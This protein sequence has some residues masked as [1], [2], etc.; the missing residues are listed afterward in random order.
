MAQAR[1]EKKCDL[2]MK[3]GVT[4]G[5]VYPRAIVELSRQYQFSSIGG[6]SAGAIAAAVAAAAEYAR[7]GGKSDA[8]DELNQLPVWLGGSS[9]D[10]KHSNLFHLFQPMPTMAK[11]YSVA[12]A[13]LGKSTVG[14]ATATLLAALR[15]F[16]IA[17]LLGVLPGVFFAVMTFQTAPESLR[18]LGQ[19]L[20]ALL[21]LVG[22]LIGIL[23]STIG[24]AARMPR[25]GW[26]ICSG[27]TEDSSGKSP[28]LVPW[29]A[30]YLDNL[31][32]KTNG[33][34]LTF[35]DLQD[36]G[37]NLQMITTNLTNGRPYSMPFGEHTHFFFKTEELRRFFPEY[38]VNSMDKHQGTRSSR[39]RDGEVQSTGLS[40]LPDAKD[41]PVILAVRM[42]LSFPFLFCPIP[43]YGVDFGFGPKTAAGS[44]YIPEPC[45]FVDG[46]LTNNFPLNLFDHPIPRWP[47]FGINLRDIDDGRHNQEVFIP[48]RN[49]GGLEEWWTRFDEKEGLGGM[50]SFFGL[51][52]D[53][54]R[55]WRDN[56]HLSAPGYRDRVVHIGL[57]PAREGGMNLDMTNDVIALLTKR[58][59]RAGGAI[60]S[61]YSPTADHPHDPNCVV[62][63][64]NQ[65]WIRFRSFM[66][67]LED[68]LLS[69]N[70]AVPYSEVGERNYEE[71]LQSAEAMS[72]PMSKPQREYAIN[73]LNTLMELVPEI[74]KMRERGQSFGTRS[75]K[76]RPDLR[77]TPHF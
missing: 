29:L 45:F 49:S 37:I 8:F 7:A 70:T 41:L 32:G 17:A 68:A 73:I 69:I 1:P 40:I 9:P 76:P 44:Q 36:R 55:N 51:L 67:L 3:G 5:V 33:E 72:Y 47:T 74:S 53:T 58:G 34:P 48:C 11:L 35:G 61:R 28:A 25:N 57:D 54:S 13:G 15:A 65:K 30:A 42:S 50:L 38:V 59:E 24:C 22:S 6:T 46:G 2:V 4:S 18:V 64:D 63:L 66:E 71:L 19:I 60:L 27:M 23:L 56:L 77:V 20:S 62:D 10:R 12:V 43:L 16:P 52:F 26:G 31:A 75:P 39:D 21:V 14:R